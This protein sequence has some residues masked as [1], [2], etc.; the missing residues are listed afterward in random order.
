VVSARS[1]LATPGGRVV[2]LGALAIIRVPICFGA[3]QFPRSPH[4]VLDIAD[5][6]ST[7]WLCNFAILEPAEQRALAHSDGHSDLS[8]SERYWALHVNTV[9]TK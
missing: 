4:P 7:L 1:V 6:G 3:L 9:D 8:G 5:F 2:V